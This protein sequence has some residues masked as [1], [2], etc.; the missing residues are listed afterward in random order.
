VIVAADDVC[1]LH[2]H[3]VDDD[4]EVVRRRAVGARDDQVVELGVIEHHVAVDHVFDHD[5]AVDRILESHH[6]IDAGTRLP[7]VPARAVVAR[8]QLRRGLPV[9]HFLQLF[10]GAVTAVRVARL[11]ELR[12]HLA[13]PIHAPRLVER[14][15]VVVQPQPLHTVENDLRRFL[16]GALAI[17]VLDAQDE[18]AAVTARVQP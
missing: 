14:T 1:H 4:A 15:L 3:V 2:V 9:A 8:L 5:R 10:P 6:R 12:E 13:I 11:E 7:A 17:G 16:G 18:H